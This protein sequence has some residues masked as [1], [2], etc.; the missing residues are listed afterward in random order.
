MPRSGYLK[1]V[2]NPTETAMADP[3]WHYSMHV[4][5]RLAVLQRMGLADLAG[6]NTWH[7]RSDLEEVLRRTLES[8]ARLRVPNLAAV[9]GPRVGA[10]LVAAAGGI[11][12]LARMPAPRIQLL[13]SRRR[14]SPERGPRF[15]VLYRAD[16]M[17]DVPIGRRGAY[18][19]TLAALA[20]I[21]IRA[22][23]HTHR[24]ISAGLVARRDR[25]VETL[26]RRRR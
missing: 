7:V 21:A 20:A 19:R 1:L 14:P 16:R 22:D 26:R 2:R 15:G 5:A 12:E 25:R 4:V 9:V 18:A 13:G 3:S 17:A 24:D 11:S 6:A 10:R 8:E 23:A